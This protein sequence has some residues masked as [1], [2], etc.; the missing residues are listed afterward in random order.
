MSPLRGAVPGSEL[1]ERVCD[2]GQIGRFAQTQG[3]KAL[4]IGKLARRSLSWTAVPFAKQVG[5][6]H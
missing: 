4:G 3:R 1:I 6:L 2:G 5:T